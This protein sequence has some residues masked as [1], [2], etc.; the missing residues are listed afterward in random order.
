MA[1]LDGGLQA[2][3]PASTV[4]AQGI[5]DLI[6]KRFA[7]RLTVESIAAAVRGKP[8]RVGRFFQLATGRTI[9]EY[10]TEVRL[11]RAAHLI[12][13]DVKIEAVAL[14]V[15][16][17]SKKNFYRQFA[18]R[19]GVT[20]E[21]YRRSAHHLRPKQPNGSGMKTYGATFDDTQC[22]IEVELQKNIKGPDSYR[23]TPFVIVPH[24]MQPF[25]APS[26]PSSI[27]GLYDISQVWKQKSIVSSGGSAPCVERS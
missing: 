19:F 20:P 12:R 24:G 13:S 26:E 23:A 7:E 15:G 3:S 4:V 8:A 10:L 27:C 11:E 21:V 9:H 14:D 22:L 5:V 2:E 16:Y 1:R 25:A 17:Q 18:R 6:E